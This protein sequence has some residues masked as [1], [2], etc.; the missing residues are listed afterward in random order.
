MI[1]SATSGFEKPR[2]RVNVTCEGTLLALSERG[3]V[4]RLP[5]A[6]TPERQTTLAIEGSG[7]ETLHLAARV[8]RSVPRAQLTSTQ[9]EHDVAIEF[10]ELPRRT[11]AAVRRIIDRH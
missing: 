2:V 1:A 7:G 6:Q 4:V 3:A 5:T 9:P 11:A 8:V 10:F